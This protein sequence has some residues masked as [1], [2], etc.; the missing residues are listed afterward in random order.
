MYKLDYKLFNIEKKQYSVTPIQSANER[1]TI[2]QA[3][4]DE[5]ALLLGRASD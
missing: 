4:C 5:T 1:V 3:M 2:N